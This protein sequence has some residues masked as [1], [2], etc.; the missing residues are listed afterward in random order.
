MR[1]MVE[2]ALWTIQSLYR[3][4]VTI[5]TDAPIGSLRSVLTDLSKKQVRRTKLIG[6]QV[7]WENVPRT[8]AIA[9]CDWM[10]LT[11]L[12]V[13]VREAKTAEFQPPPCTTGEGDR[14]R[15]KGCFGRGKFSYSAPK[16][17]SS[18]AMQ[19]V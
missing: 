1:S 3:K 10:T 9:T 7:V 14:L 6:K 12:P 16:N 4:K 5:V 2:G 17:S 18:R 11:A 8:R 15:W 13:S 19:S